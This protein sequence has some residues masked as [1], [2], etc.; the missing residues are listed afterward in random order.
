MCQLIGHTILPF[1]DLTKPTEKRNSALPVTSSVRNSLK[2]SQKK[3]YLCYTYIIPFYIL[4]NFEFSFE[5]LKM[6][7][8][9]FLTMQNPTKIPFTIPSQNKYTE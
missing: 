3:A 9:I 6:Q 8:P 5:H 1:C 4:F 7:Q 2:S